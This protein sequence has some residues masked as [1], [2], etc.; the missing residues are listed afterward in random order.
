MPDRLFR[1]GLVATSAG[2]ARDWTKLAQQAENL[3]FS[4]LLMPDGVGIQSAFPALAA[5]A[6][7]TERLRFGN[8]VLAAPL[9][10]P[11]LIAW[12]TATLDQLSEGRFELGI[13]AGRPDGAHNAEVLG[14]PYGTAGSR[15]RQVAEI[16]DTVDRLFLQ[17][18]AFQPVQKPRPPIMVAGGGDKLLTVAA[19]R[20]DIL[21]VHADG[22]EAGLA[23]KLGLVREIAGQRF[24]D[25][26]LSVNVFSVGDGELSPFVQR[27]GIDPAQAKDNAHVSVLNG[28]SPADVLKRRRDELGISYVTFNVQTLDSA[29]PI[30]E[31]LAGT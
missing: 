5:A 1:F 13:G 9:R 3:G 26:E 11:G 25:L 22:S 31:E 10:P 14:V 2:S 16:I 24:D 18:K 17:D 21:A 23:T 30:V 20:A 4:T 27:F 6:A 15:V 28:S 29:A 12:E 8:F 19:Q 7:T